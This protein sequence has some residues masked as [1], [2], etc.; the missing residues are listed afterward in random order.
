MYKSAVNLGAA[1]HDSVRNMQDGGDVTLMDLQTTAPGSN[2]DYLE[3]LPEEFSQ[4]APEELGL[5]T[6]LYDKLLGEGDITK[7][8]RESGRVGDSMTTELYGSDP[9]FM[10]QLIEDYKYPAVMDK[11]TGEMVIP[12]DRGP[13]EVRMARPLGR[14]DLPTYPEL[15]DARAHM[16]GSAMLAQKYGLETAKKAGDFKEFLDRFA[17]FPSG[18][19]NERDAAMDKR[20][21]AVGRQIFMKAG[22]NATPQQLTRM[23]EAEIFNQLDVIMGR[24]LEERSTPAPGQPRA[25]RNFMSP[26]TG[27]DVYFPRNEKGYF[28]T[29]RNILY[30]SRGK[31]PDYQ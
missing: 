11:E 19:Q 27:P 12:T 21:N 17:P 4:G 18:G 7:G 26:K 24:S 6:L 8:L 29:T 23:V 5:S 2:P 30:F 15:E 22:I 1:G 31:Y 20:N 3:Y 13:E 9:S 28:D 25:P 14:R 16:L 10:Q